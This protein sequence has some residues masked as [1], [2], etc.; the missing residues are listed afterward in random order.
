MALRVQ[1]ESSNDIGVFSK[2]T[3]SYA[4][5]GIGGSENFYSVFEGELSETIPVVHA[6]IAGCRIIGRLCVGNK[7]GLLVPSSTFDTE[8]QHI[9]NAL[10]DSVKVQRVEERLSA[11]GNV[12]ACNDY[13]ALVHPDLDRETEEII[14]D[15]LKV[16]VFRQ[17]VASN[18]LVGSYSVLSNQGGLIHPNTSVADL[19][20]LSS[21]LQVPLVAGTVNRGSDLIG[22]GLVVNDWCAFAGTDTTST[23]LTVIESVFR[24]NEANPSAITSSM[25]ASL[26]ES[27]S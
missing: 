27:M 8:L 21:L 19:E 18:V 22:A 5:V 1:F 23:E 25:R 12:V 15:T 10:P 13:V 3:N 26:I 7:N 2:L 4:L 11:L 14:A 16:E 9:R 24:L 17:T 20:E 6:S